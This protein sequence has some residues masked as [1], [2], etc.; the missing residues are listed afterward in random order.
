MSPTLHSFT[1]HA[2]AACL[3]AFGGTVCA[4]TLIDG[5]FENQA[6]LQSLPGYAALCRAEPAGRDLG[7]RLK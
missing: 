7:R 1:A 5:S 6:V 4:T 2:A 3:L